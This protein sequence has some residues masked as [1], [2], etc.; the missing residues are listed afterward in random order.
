MPKP[1][2]SVHVA[3]QR[4]Q[5]DQASAYREIAYGD[6]ARSVHAYYEDIDSLVTALHSAGVAIDEAAI[7]AVDSGPDG[8]SVIVSSDLELDEAQRRAL[9]LIPERA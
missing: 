1:K 8:P 9:G 2:E 3:I 7:R 6:E 4:I 5:M